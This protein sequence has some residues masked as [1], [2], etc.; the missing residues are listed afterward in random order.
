MRTILKNTI[1]LAVFLCAATNLTNIQSSMAQLSDETDP[2]SS[3]NSPLILQAP[4]IS[5]QVSHLHRHK[6]NRFHHLYTGPRFKASNYLMIGLFAS[7]FYGLRL[8]HGLFPV[9]MRR[10]IT[11]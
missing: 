8:T 1:V 10:A 5:H 7:V 3:S 2:P 9:A 11:Q 4:L 6:Y